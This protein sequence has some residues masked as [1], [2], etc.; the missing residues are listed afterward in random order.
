[1]SVRSEKATIQL[2]FSKENLEAMMF[3]MEEKDTTVE[4]ELQSHI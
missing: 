1:M 3:Y 2:S 4:K